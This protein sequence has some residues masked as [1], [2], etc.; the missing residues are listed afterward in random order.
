M[1]ELFGPYHVYE[2]LGTGGMA[3]V[4]RAARRGI[5]GFEKVVALKR[6]LP[7]VAENHDFVSSFIREA[8]LGSML[9]H[10]RIVQTFDLGRVDAHT[11]V[12][13][14]IFSEVRGSAE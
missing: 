1:D 11:D 10:S 8:K 9:R 7:Q 6:L 2:C 5:E 3:T 14:R 13:W 12:L 4:H